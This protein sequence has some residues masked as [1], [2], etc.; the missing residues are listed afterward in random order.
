MASSMQVYLKGTS[1]KSQIWS[2]LQWTTNEVGEIPLKGKEEK[3][4]TAISYFF[5]FLLSIVFYSF[6]VLAPN[7]FTQSCQ[8]W[9]KTPLPPTICKS[10]PIPLTLQLKNQKPV[11]RFSKFSFLL[12]LLFRATATKKSA[13]NSLYDRCHQNTTV[14]EIGENT[15]KWKDIPCLWTGRISI[16]KMSILPKAIYRFNAIPI[17]IPMTFFMELEQ[18]ILKFVWTTKDPE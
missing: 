5:S 17:K 15:N 13:N 12:L 1:L 2:L 8:G 11:T 14:L 4:G 16:V 9:C 10:F 18:I 7:S 6:W 3:K